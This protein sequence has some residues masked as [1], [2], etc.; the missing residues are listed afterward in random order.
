MLFKAESWSELRLGQNEQGT[1]VFSSPQKPIFP[2]SNS[3]RNQVDEEPLCGCATSKS[4]FIIYLFL[5]QP[6]V[7][8]D[9]TNCGNNTFKVM[10]KKFGKSSPKLHG[11]TVLVTKIPRIYPLE[12]SLQRNLWRTHSGGAVLNF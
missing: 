5:L 6:F 12:P 3:T 4:L 8:S 9:M 2:N 1:P 11:N 10:C 7:G